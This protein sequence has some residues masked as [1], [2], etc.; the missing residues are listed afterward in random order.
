[1]DQANDESSQ[2]AFTRAA[3]RARTAHTPLRLG[4]IEDIAVEGTVLSFRRISGEAIVQCQFNLGRDSAAMAV[5]PM[6]GSVLEAL[7][8]GRDPSTTMLPPMSALVI[9]T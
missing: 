9:H 4:S 2:L 5:E 1:M 3:V 6:K 7:S 8:P